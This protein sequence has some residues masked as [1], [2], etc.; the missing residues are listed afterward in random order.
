MSYLDPTRLHFAGKFQAAPSTVNNDPVHFDNST[1]KKEYQLLETSTNPPNN[2][3]WNPR[4]DADF[5]LIGCKV[6]SAWLAGSQVDFDNVL[7]CLILDSGTRVAGKIVDLDSEQQMVSMLFGLEVRICTA[8]GKQLMKGRYQ[9]GAFADI[10]QRAQAAGGDMAYGAMY[11]STLEALEWGDVSGSPFLSALKAAAATGRLS[12]KFNVDGYNMNYGSPDFTRGRVVGTIGPAAEDEPS[13]LVLGRH[14]LSGATS[15]LGCCVGTLNS[16]TSPY[17][18]LDLGNAL[19]T[20][21]PG[22]PLADLGALTLAYQPPP[23]AS[24]N[25]VPPVSLGTIPYTDPGWYE[26]T[27]GVVDIPVDPANLTGVQQNSLLLLLPPATGS[28][29]PTVGVS[30]PPDGLYVRADQFVFRLNPGESRHAVL[31]ATQFGLNVI[32]IADPSQLQPQTSMPGR[33]APP[34]AVPADAVTFPYCVV[35]DAKG[36]AKLPIRTKNPGNPRGYID[37]QVYGIRPM[38]EETMPPPYG[39]PFN[40]WEFIS[41]LLWDEFQAEDPPT[42]YGSIYPTFKQ[43]ANLYPIMDVFLDLGD[44]D[45]VCKHAGLLSM[46]FR[47]PIEDPNSMPVTRDLS[48]AK[49]SVIVKWLAKPL[50]GTPPPLPPEP[51]AQDVAAPAAPAGPPADRGGKAAAMARRV[52]VQR[53]KR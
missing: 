48:E 26:A 6:T 27:A 42:W 10:W 30:E 32:T 24:G 39:Y 44:Y 16:G 5:R 53:S 40:Q 34:V 37:G 11:Q 21:T 13:F 47:L 12:I 46:A 52:V 51:P 4:G 3:W 38:L 50:K 8:D 43:Y 1:F 35:T 15:S 2:G 18:M 36:I 19:P 20:S 28:N 45:S 17:I 22:S 29:T 14:F 31:Y 9:P 23:D 7:Q 25:P 33:A 41:I 49:R